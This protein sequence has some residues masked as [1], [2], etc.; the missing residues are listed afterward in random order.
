MGRNHAR[1]YSEMGVLGGVFD[2]NSIAAKSIA[3]RYGSEHYSELNE[4]FNNVDVVSIST[5][6]VTHY[7]ITSLAIEKGVSVL[8]EKPFTGSVVMAQ[9]LTQKAEDEGVTLTVGMVERHNPVVNEARNCL[10]RGDFGDLITISSRRVSSFPERI[11]DVGVVMDLGIH[12]IDALSFISNSRVKSVFAHGGRYNGSQFEDHANIMMLM[13][14]G[15]EA[16]VEVNWLTPMKVRNVYMTCSKTYAKLDYM[17]QMISTSASRYVG[18][19]ENDYRSP[20]EFEYSERFLKK[21]EPLKRELSNFIESSKG[22]EKPL[23]TGW[24]VVEDL[25]VCEAV[26]RSIAEMSRIDIL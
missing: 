8:I 7:E 18:D 25:K 12:D 9:E 17:S 5:P 2:L 14:N 24:E 20:W 4:L 21:E 15:T 6:T 23:V 10:E 26:L 3:E 1:I 19:S 22:N 16:F 13:E 11:R